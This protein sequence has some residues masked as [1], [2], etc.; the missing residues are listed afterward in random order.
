MKTLCMG[1][2]T[3]ENNTPAIRK[4]MQADCKKLMFTWLSNASRPSSEQ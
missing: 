1:I 4:K 3:S 2:L